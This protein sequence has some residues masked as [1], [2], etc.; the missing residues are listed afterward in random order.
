M[1]HRQS[2]TTIKILFVLILFLLNPYRK[3][4]RA[5]AE[6]PLNSLLPTNEAWKRVEDPQNYLPES[7]YEYINGAAEIYLA[8]DFKELVVCQYE[9]VDA[10]ASLSVEIYDMGNEK[11]SFGIYSA[12]RFPDMRFVT[13]GN[14]GYLEEGTLNF[15]VGRYYVKL[16]CFDCDQE[17]ESTLKLFADEIL[18]G[19]KDK[20]QMPPLINVFPEEGLIANSEKFIL[21]NFL[22]YA[23]LHDGYL[24]DYKRGELEFE[25]FLVEGKSQDETQKMLDKYLD[26]KKGNIER[27]SFGYHLKDRYYHNIYLARIQNYLCGVFKIKDGFEEVGEIYLKSLAKSLKDSPMYHH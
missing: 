5:E 4:L 12:E 7:L 26:R 18:A 20:A 21:Q 24:A 14:Q 11:N 17:S 10:G 16:L 6:F 3:L 9:K 22:G 27:K 15:M 23:F 19:V 25:C 8:Y 2:T 13:V 1:R